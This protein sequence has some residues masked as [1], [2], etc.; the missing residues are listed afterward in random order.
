MW[1]QYAENHSGVC[2]IFDGPKL[3]DNLEKV[4]K[5]PCTI[6]RGFVRYNYEKSTRQCL[7][8]LQGYDHHEVTERI[9]ESFQKFYEENFL[10]KSPEWKTEHEYRW[11]VHC[12]EDLSDPDDLSEFLFVPI[13]GAIK[14]V[15]VGTGFP[16]VYKPSLEFLCTQLAIPGGKITWDHG[17]PWVKP[18]C[19]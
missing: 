16:E 13:D 3:N 12:P 1:A 15:I 10:F 9:R 7:P 17:M 18:F 19:N 6:Y 14:A 4:F 5:T 11:L 8:N 2:L